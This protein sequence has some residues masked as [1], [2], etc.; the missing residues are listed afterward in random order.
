M[1]LNHLDLQ[2]SDVPTHVQ[3]FEEFFGLELQSNRN[4]PAIAILSDGH[5]FVLVLQ[6]KS[7]PNECYPEGFHCGFLVDDPAVVH[8][9]HKRLREAG[10]EVSDVQRD[11]RGTRV[12]CRAPDGFLVEVSCRP[13]AH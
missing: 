2:V 7:H 10:R 13:A 6:R 9:A 1:K 8:A 4:S 11:N 3:F 12:Y 5:G